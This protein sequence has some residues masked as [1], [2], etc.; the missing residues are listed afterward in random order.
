[1]HCARHE[2]RLL[3]A[4]HDTEGV[5][6]HAL[7]YNQKQ[8]LPVVQLREKGFCE[9]QVLYSIK[10]FEDYISMLD[11]TTGDAMTK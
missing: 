9:P 3:Q 7:C 2:Q 5:P 8:P 4:E 6:V 1:M 10:A 11:L